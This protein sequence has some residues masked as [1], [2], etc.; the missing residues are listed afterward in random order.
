MSSEFLN[1]NGTEPVPPSL[2]RPFVK[3]GVEN[4]PEVDDP[5]EEDEPEH[6]R[7]TKLND[8][9]QESTLQELPETRDEETAERRDDV[10]AGTLTCHGKI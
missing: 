7:E 8:R 10:A 3:G 6:G 1:T 5:P 4:R 9:D 2:G